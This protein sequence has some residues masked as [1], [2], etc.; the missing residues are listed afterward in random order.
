MGVD[1]AREMIKFTFSCVFGRDSVKLGYGIVVF[2]LF[3][4]GMSSFSFAQTY[5]TNLDGVILKNV[6]CHSS[7]NGIGLNVS[8][9]SARAVQGYLIATIFDVEGDPVDNGKAKISVGPVSGDRIWIKVS[10]GNGA[11]FAFRIN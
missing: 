2:F 10:C 7:G 5:P 11:K 9:R 6:K 8:N 3:C 1:V 4:L